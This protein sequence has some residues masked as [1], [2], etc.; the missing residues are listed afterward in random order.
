MGGGGG[1]LAREAREMA[2]EESSSVGLEL[3]APPAKALPN[4]ESGQ[5]NRVTR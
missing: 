3:K 2:G 1:F 5:P 4:P